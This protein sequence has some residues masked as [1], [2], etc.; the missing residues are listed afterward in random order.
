MKTK[1]LVPAP[2]MYAC[3]LNAHGDNLEVVGGSL[4]DIRHALAEA[5]Y[6]GP[7]VLVVRANDE[8]VGWADATDYRST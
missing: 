2:T 8:L 1:L 7:A 5:G 6:D 3:Y 4:E